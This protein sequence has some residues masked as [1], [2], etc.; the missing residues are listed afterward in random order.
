[1]FTTAL[2]E[3]FILSRPQGASHRSTDTHDYAVDNLGLS[4]AGAQ[5]ML[6]R[7]KAETGVRGSAHSYRA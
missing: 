4:M 6:K 5:T 7:L 1:V 3:K 2:L